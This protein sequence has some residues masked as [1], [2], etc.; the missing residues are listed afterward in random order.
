MSKSY[1][2]ILPNGNLIL[3][4]DLRLS[5]PSNLLFRMMNISKFTKSNQFSAKRKPCPAR[6][7]HPIRRHFQRL[8]YLNTLLRNGSW[9][10]WNVIVIHA[11]RIHYFARGR[12]CHIVP[13]T[14]QRVNI[15]LG[16]KR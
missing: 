12:Q 13:S 9:R 15:H 14:H 16:L 11:K 1:Q 10:A 2:N 7:F 4:S 5:G 8:N 3:I 6:L